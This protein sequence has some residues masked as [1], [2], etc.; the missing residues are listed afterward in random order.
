VQR[1]HDVVHKGDGASRQAADE[2][3]AVAEDWFEYIAS[4]W[5]VH[6]AARDVSA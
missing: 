6:R 4:A 2:S 1:R 3:I 5:D